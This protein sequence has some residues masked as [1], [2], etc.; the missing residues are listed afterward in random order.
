MRVFIA[1]SGGRSNFIAQA[2][3]DWLPMVVPSVKP[4]VS[5]QDIYKGERWMAEAAKVL[6]ESDFGILC[7]T[8]ENLK[9]EWIHFESGALSKRVGLARVV[10]YLFD[11]DPSDLVMPL[12]QFQAAKADREDTL[13]TVQSLNA[14]CMPDITLDEARLLK[15]F[16]KFWPD[17]YTALD[18][19]PSAEVALPDVRRTDREVLTEILELVRGAGRT[20]DLWSAP[21]YNPDTSDVVPRC[22]FCDREGTAY[23]GKIRKVERLLGSD[24]GRRYWIQVRCAATGAVNEFSFDAYSP[25]AYPDVHKR[26]LAPMCADFVNAKRQSANNSAV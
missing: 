17:L 24:H 7:L 11:L 21:V 25:D 26:P 22:S 19:V 14:A 16:D 12:S 2:L 23:E 15:F 1:W 18:T 10:P 13:R 8:P 20:A 3:G 5:S 9:S 4:W 6:D